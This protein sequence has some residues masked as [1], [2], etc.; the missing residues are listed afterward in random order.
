MNPLGLIIFGL[1]IGSICGAV[2]H[3]VAESKKYF[4]WEYFVLGLLGGPLGVA[5]IVAAPYARPRPHKGMR[6]VT[7]PRC[8]KVQNIDQT[9]TQLDCWQCGLTAD[10]SVPYPRRA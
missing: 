10:T 5:A 9:S 1:I 6:Q 3:E 2:T 8:M 7:C 4:G